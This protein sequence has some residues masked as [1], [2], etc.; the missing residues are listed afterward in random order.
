MI[1]KEERED[2]KSNVSQS[3]KSVEKKYVKISPLKAEEPKNILKEDAKSQKGSVKESP[4][5]VFDQKS[6]KS[7]KSKASE[8]KANENQKAAVL[9]YKDDLVNEIMGIKKVIEKKDVKISPLKAEEPKNILKEDAKSQ[10][11]AIKE[12]PPK[13]SMPISKAFDQKSQQSKV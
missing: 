10:K 4:P 11:S 12:S 8:E 5:K 6:Q 7:Q 13:I 3:K 1:N 2:V 9:S